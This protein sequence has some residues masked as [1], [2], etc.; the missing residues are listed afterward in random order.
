MT[1]IGPFKDFKTLALTLSQD[2]SVGYLYFGINQLFSHDSQQL[3]E[4]MGIE[5]PDG[6]WRHAGTEYGGTKA[7]EG[8][9]EGAMRR[10]P[11]TGL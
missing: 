9:W 5:G 10:Q 7:G 2:V 6:G 3:N 8:P 11:L 4:G 1:S